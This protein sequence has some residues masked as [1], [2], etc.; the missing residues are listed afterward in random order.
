MKNKTFTQV[1]L[2]F[3]YKLLCSFLLSFTKIFS[4]S[5]RREERGVFAKNSFVGE[6]SQKSNRVASAFLGYVINRQHTTVFCDSL[7]ASGKRKQN[8][9]LFKFFPG[10]QNCLGFILLLLTLKR[11]TYMND[12]V[13][14][15]LIA[16]FISMKTIFSSI[17]KQNST[18]HSRGWKLRGCS[19][20][21]VFILLIGMNGW[22][23]T[24]VTFTATNASWNVPANVSTMTI[25]C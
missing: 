9:N 7:P 3:P 2:L 17:S 11:K 21:S 14:M 12:F 6:S 25:E 22:G 23:Q 1:F 15:K 4:F 24:T 16:M 13:S 18:A 10:L 20:F 19:L 5:S 8:Y